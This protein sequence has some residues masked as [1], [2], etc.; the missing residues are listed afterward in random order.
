MNVKENK[1]MCQ[2]YIFDV[3]R[4]F[5]ISVFKITRVNISKDLCPKIYSV[6]LPN[7][8]YVGRLSAVEFAV[9]ARDRLIFLIIARQVTS[10]V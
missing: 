6:L 1:E 5:E 2:N 7:L 3:R 8:L 9:I 4:H 10:H